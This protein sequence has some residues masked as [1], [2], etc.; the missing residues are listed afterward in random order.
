MKLSQNG[1]RDILL[2]GHQILADSL[3]PFSLLLASKNIQSKPN[4]E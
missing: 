3:L 2:D 4:Y 1:F